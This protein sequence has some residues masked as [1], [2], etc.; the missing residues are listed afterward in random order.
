MATY[1]DIK[2]WN[3]KDQFYFFK[4][5]DNPFFNIC[6][7]V[8]VTELLKQTKASNKSFFLTS[9]FMSLKAA[10]DI[11]EFRYRILD[12]KIIA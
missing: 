1:L 7:E 5:Y 3:R 10:N 4:D 2:N 6:A 9:L 8:D 11:Q 12:E